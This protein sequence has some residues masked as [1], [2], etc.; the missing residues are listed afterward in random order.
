MNIRLRGV[1]LR[2]TAIGHSVSVLEAER[3]RRLLGQG[4]AVP[5]AVGGSDK[6]SDDLETPLGNIHRFSPQIREAKVDVE[7]E[8]IDTSRGRGHAF[9][10]TDRIGRTY[11]ARSNPLA[12]IPIA[13]GSLKASASR[14]RRLSFTSSL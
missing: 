2:D 8:K 1:A 10:R 3:A 14:P 11:R 6:R 4:V 7:L 12:R 9:E 5:L 13:Q